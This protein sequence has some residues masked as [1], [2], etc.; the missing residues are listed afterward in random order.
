MLELELLSGPMQLVGTLLTATIV[1]FFIVL[2]FRKDSITSPGLFT[3]AI[4]CLGTSI[5]LPLMIMLIGMATESEA[6]GAVMP[7]FAAFSP[8]LFFASILMAMLAMVPTRG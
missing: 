5:L 6:I 7:Y 3:G 2:A 8:L 4:I 1:M